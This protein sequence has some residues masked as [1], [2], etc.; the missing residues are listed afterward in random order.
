MKICAFN[1]CNNH[2][3][4]PFSQGVSSICPSCRERFNGMCRGGIVSKVSDMLCEI[5]K[6]TNKRAPIADD[7]DNAYILSIWP[8]SNHCP[9]LH[10]EFVVGTRYAAS[11]DR[12]DNNKPYE[13]GNL[14]II[15]RKANAMKND[16][17]TEELLLFSD[18]IRSTYDGD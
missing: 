11:L 2:Y 6:H 12:I 9:I 14:Q 1:G 17:S 5:K 10:E 13:R 4:T 15:S 3:E 7:V 18:W 16:A 8:V